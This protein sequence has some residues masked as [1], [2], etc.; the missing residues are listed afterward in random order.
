MGGRPPT[1]PRPLRTTPAGAAPPGSSSTGAG[2][3]QQLSQAPLATAAAAA[4]ASSW[5]APLVFDA[6]GPVA[7]AARVALALLQSA[8]PYVAERLAAALGRAGG[9]GGWDSGEGGLGLGGGLPVST[10]GGGSWGW[11]GRSA[12]GDES[13]SDS[14]S[15]GSDGGSTPSR[16]AE[17]GSEGRCTA[18]CWQ[19]LQQLL[20]HHPSSAQQRRRWRRRGQGEGS[21]TAWQRVRGALA[22]RWPQIWE[23]GG[24][25]LRAHLAL[26]YLYGTYYHWEKRL[27]GVTYTSTS[28]FTE[29][30]TSYQVGDAEGRGRGIL[31]EWARVGGG[32]HDGGYLQ[33]DPSMEV[34]WHEPLKEAASC[35]QCHI[36]ETSLTPNP[37]HLAGCWWPNWPYLRLCRPCLSCSKSSR[38]LALSHPAW[39]ACQLSMGNMQSCYLIA[40]PQY[41]AAA[42]AAQ[43]QQ[44]QQGRSGLQGL[45]GSVA[46]L[47]LVRASNAP[48]AC[49]HAATPHARHADMCFAG[50][51]SPSGATRSPNAPCAARLSYRRSSCV[52]TIQI[53]ELFGSRGTVG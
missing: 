44:Q 39:R 40:P 48:C 51:A 53:F 12:G 32:F 8:G 2:G 38:Q 5:S 13:D 29:R 30:R 23:W 27:L 6:R 11:T 46:V 16:S 45:Q 4:A 43:Q 28:P 34:Q 52:C 1:L 21:S 37:R 9:V 50:T 19:Q 25:G 42:V 22:Q 10:G 49:R 36:R 7:P 20:P 31:V 35:G 33:G 26:F 14:D 47:Q 17:D 3:Q 41:L 18:S 15:D 24:F